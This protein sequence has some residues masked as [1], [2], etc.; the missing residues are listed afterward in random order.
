MH[1]SQE[2]GQQQLFTAVFLRIFLELFSQPFLI[3]PIFCVNAAVPE[4]APDQ[5]LGSGGI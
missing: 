2:A 3:L 1:Q 4:A 5:E